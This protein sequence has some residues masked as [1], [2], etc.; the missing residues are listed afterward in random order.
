ME[1]NQGNPPKAGDVVYIT[2]IDERDR[3]LDGKPDLHTLVY[4]AQVARLFT[5][6][7]DGRT[8]AFVTDQNDST[9]FLLAPGR[10]WRAFTTEPEAETEGRAQYLDRAG[11]AD[12][13]PIKKH[14][15]AR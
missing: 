1:V 10:G 7:N 2:W 3:E 15:L 11:K 13:N 5:S 9:A 6:G 12:A 8:S 14:G 4:K